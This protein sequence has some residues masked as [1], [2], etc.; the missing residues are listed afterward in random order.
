MKDLGSLRKNDAFAGNG[1]GDERDILRQAAALH[2]FDGVHGRDAQDGGS[3]FASFFDDAGNLFASDERAY[4]VVHRHQFHIISDVIEGGG[5]GF[6][7]GGSAFDHSNRLREFFVPKTLF[8]AL[9]FIGAGGDD[10]FTDGIA[11][12][13]A[14]QGV[15]KDGRAVQFEELFGRFAAHARAH[16]SGGQ[17]GWEYGH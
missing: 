17:E 15:E 6:L 1:A 12:G 8:H 11:G 10:D 14:A 13:E 2:F 16:S 9:D 5:D 3:A 7:P 4:R